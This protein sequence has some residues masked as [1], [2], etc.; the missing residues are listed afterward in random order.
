MSEKISEF[1]ILFESVPGLFLVL[2]PDLTIHAVSDDYASATLTKREEITGKFLFDVFPDNPDDD[3]ADAVSQTSFSLN[4]V[5][6]NKKAHTMAVQ[7]RDI[8]RLDGTFE[9]RYWSLVNKPVLNSN[10]E[11]IYIIQR[12]EDVTDFIRLKKEQTVKDEMAADLH[13]RSLEM[14]IE[15]IKRSQEIQKI[16]RE[17]ERKVEERTKE[18]INKNKNIS[19]YKL[20]LDESCLVAVTDHNG[21]IQHVNDNFCKISKYTR[22]ELIGSD[23]RILNSGYHSKEF[24]RELWTTIAKGAIWKGEIRNKARDGTVYWIYTTIVPFLDE[25]GKPYKYMTV[26]FDITQAKQSVEEVKASEK[27]Y[28]N[29]FENSLVG[30]FTSDLKTL[31]V[32]EANKVGLELLGYKTKKAF[33]DGFD[34]SFHSIDLEG[35]RKN[36]ETLK[37]KGELRNQ[38]QEMRKLD[39]TRFWANLYIKLDTIAGIIQTTIID[40]TPQ[41][42]SG[43]ELKMS[44]EKYRNIYQNSIVSMHTIDINTHKAIEAN[45][46]SVKLFGYPSKTEFLDKYNQKNHFVKSQELEKKMEILQKKGEVKRREIE[47][48]RL[49]GSRFW[50]NIFV[51]LNSDNRTAQTIVID[52]TET[53]RSR[54]ELEG[55]V[56]ERTLELTESLQ[57][58]KELNEIKSKFVSMASHEFRTPLAAILSSAS[59]IEMYKEAEQQEK[60]VK[61]VKRISSS[62]EN[63][64]GILNNFLS[65]GQLENGVLNV[66]KSEINLPEFI[67]ETVAELDGRI[68]EKSQQVLFCHSGAEII[69]QS[70][71]IL[72]NVLLNLV[73]NA[74]KYSHKEAEIHVTSSVAGNKVTISVKDFGIGIPEDDQKH[75]FTEFFRGGNVEGIQGTGLGLCIV[76]KYIELIGGTIH[77]TTKSGEGSVFTI[78]FTDYGTK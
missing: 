14:E 4:Y 36:M 44:E 29:V 2:L 16:N 65:L 46:M 17:L 7:R 75:L 10:N 20:A 28:R 34:P 1:K 55:K 47:M 54:E 19:D 13:V 73:S 52:I 25:R 63:L 69:E 5:L 6:K 42:E 18:L 40:I 31:K 3:T 72:K 78:E 49:D 23:H 12:V 77:F 30:L 53:M 33:M 35:W 11:V 8:C 67:R 70:G 24:M 45:A 62:V 32:T 58:E 51:K 15:V 27:K 60:R 50:A 59:I 56:K 57:R 9:E 41:I 26:R 76:K 21:I 66:K 48:K 38:I 74:S 39:G 22:N 64:T 37:I 61:H 71:K 43:R 68:A